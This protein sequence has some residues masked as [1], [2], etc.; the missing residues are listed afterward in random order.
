LKRQ[1]VMQ[2]NYQ[3]FTLLEKSRFH[4]YRGGWKG[5]KKEGRQ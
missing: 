1:E 5:Y 2:N 4:S 3:A